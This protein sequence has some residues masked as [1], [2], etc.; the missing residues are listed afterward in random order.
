MHEGKMRVSTELWGRIS[1]RWRA[2]PVS[3]SGRRFSWVD[4][5]CD[6]GA[7]VSRPVFSCVALRCRFERSDV[8]RTVVAAETLF[9]E[10]GCADCFGWCGAAA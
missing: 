2:Y 7:E 5:A 6:A 9:A 1:D 3:S 10:D 4:S 8:A